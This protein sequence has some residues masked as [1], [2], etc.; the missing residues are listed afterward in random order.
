M[1]KNVEQKGG[2]LHWRE[3]VAGILLDGSCVWVCWTDHV[4]AIT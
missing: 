1:Q 3:Q 2:C 4:D